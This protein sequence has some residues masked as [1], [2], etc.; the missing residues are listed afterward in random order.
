MIHRIDHDCGYLASGDNVR[1]CALSLSAVLVLALGLCSELNQDGIFQ[2]CGLF[3]FYFCTDGSRI[4]RFVYRDNPIG[5]RAGRK[6]NPNLIVNLIFNPI[7]SYLP[8]IFSYWQ[9]VFHT[10]DYPQLIL[11]LD[12]TCVFFSTG[13]EV[14][15]KFLRPITNLRW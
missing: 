1:R 11:A 14:N 6:K 7:A 3:R 10:T 12:N 5:F 4:V 2:L 13:P 15:F 8:L 9:L